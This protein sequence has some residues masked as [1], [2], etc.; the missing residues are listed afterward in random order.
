MSYDVT[1]ILDNQP[2]QLATMG[3]VLGEA[4]ITSM[5][6]ADSSLKAKA[7]YISWSEMD[8]L[9]AEPWRMLGLLPEMFDSYL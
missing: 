9:P 4:E 8:P 7:R 5:I 1:I 2:G 3:E 6:C